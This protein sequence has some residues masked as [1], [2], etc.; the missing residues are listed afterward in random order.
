MCVPPYL[1]LSRAG[2]VGAC[3]PQQRPEWGVGVRWTLEA[4]AVMKANRPLSLYLQPW[5]WWQRPLERLLLSRRCY[6]PTCTP[7]VNIWAFI[8]NVFWSLFSPNAW[9]QRSAPMHHRACFLIFLWKIYYDIT[10]SWIHVANGMVYIVDRIKPI[11]SWWN[12]M[13]TDEV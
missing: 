12:N 2:L 10:Q 8:T 3:R 7:M 9:D 5:S 13:Q 11:F 4:V 1:L 6:M